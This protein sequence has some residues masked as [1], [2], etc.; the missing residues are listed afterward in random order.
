MPVPIR[1]IGFRHMHAV[2]SMTVGNSRL[3][4]TH[5][6]GADATIYAEGTLLAARKVGSITGL[7]RGLDNLL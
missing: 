3:T 7:V 5:D 4:I 2:P 1:P 6:A